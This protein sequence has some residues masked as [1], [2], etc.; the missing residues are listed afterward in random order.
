MTNTV[1]APKKTATEKTPVTMSDGRVVE[2]NK[3]QKLVKSS[4]ISDSGDVSVRLDFSNGETRTFVPRED[5]IARFAAHGIEQKLGDAIAGENDINDAVLSVD[6]LIA[7]LNNG[8]WNITRAAGGFSGTSILIQ[9]LVEASGK[10]VPAIKAFLE[11]KSQAEKLALRRSDKLRPIIEKLEA[12]KASKSGNQVD[13]GALLE[14]LGLDASAS[15]KK[16]K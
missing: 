16:A 1:E 14:E 6:D 2:F 10:D 5:M 4:T 8:E 13:T 9:A 3:K 11:N 7:R 15:P 12:A